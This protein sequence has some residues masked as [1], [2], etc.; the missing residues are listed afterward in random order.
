MGAINSQMKGVF[1]LRLQ[2]VMCEVS[3]MC[4]V[5]SW[6]RRLKKDNWL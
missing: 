4:Q 5:S 1:S 3:P 2:G 6:D